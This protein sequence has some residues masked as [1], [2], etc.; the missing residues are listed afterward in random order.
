MK[1][2]DDNDNVQSNSYLYN[3]MVTKRMIM[4]LTTNISIVK[5]T[6][7]TQTTY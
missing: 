5:T 1:C 7:I 4:A 2:D 3:V 6:T